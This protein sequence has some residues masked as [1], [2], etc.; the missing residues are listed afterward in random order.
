M[1]LDEDAMAAG[2]LLAR[3]RAGDNEA[4]AR[5]TEPHRHELLVHCYRMLGSLQDAEDALQETLLAAWQALA[6]FELRSSLR[7]W[8]YTIA[9]HRCL[10]ARRATR[11]RSPTEWDVPGVPPPVPSR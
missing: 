1:D 9:T 4:F 5:L 8:L 6:G 7:T 10:T 3:A 2:Q 11:R